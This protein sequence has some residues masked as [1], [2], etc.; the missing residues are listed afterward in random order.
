[1]SEDGEWW[2]GATVDHGVVAGGT[3][4]MWKWNGSAYVQM[5]VI[6]S[7]DIAS[8]DKFGYRVAISGSTM[9][10]S[11][12]FDGSPDN[13]G[14]VYMF[15]RTGDVWNE[16][17]KIRTPYPNIP[18]DV[19]EDEEFG[20]L[21]ALDGDHMCVSQPGWGV[22]EVDV[23][24]E[25]AI[26]F[27][28]RQGTGSGS[29]WVHTTLI[30]HT[31]LGIHGSS[32]GW[33]LTAWMALRDMGDLGAWCA[34]G[35]SSYSGTRPDD[36]VYI[37]KYGGQDWVQTQLLKSPDE[38]AYADFGRTVAMTDG[39]LIVG[40]SGT[41]SS[42]V[43]GFQL[44]G[45]TWVWK[46]QFTPPPEADPGVSGFGGQSSNARGDYLII[47]GV[48]A[49]ALPD[50][51]LAFVY[52]LNRQTQQWEQISTLNRAVP[53]TNDNFG[54]YQNACISNNGRAIVGSQRDSAGGTGR[55]SVATF[56]QNP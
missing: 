2:A 20:T 32:F 25:G 7:S 45:N 12:I 46:Q 29:R 18:G 40:Q 13:E 33:D 11:A 44:I 36:G 43:F 28:H 34:M 48:E 38:I 17:Q 5:Q 15:E 16:V 30:T 24:Y 9:A 3:V 22:S 53:D 19:Y 56:I 21:L 42:S 26:L 6:Q 14:A 50:S 41:I 35:S 1:M 27:F 4:Y 31:S 10:V 37:Y 47:G 23:I 8:A 54:W 39:W 51:Y 55:G 52:L 49:L